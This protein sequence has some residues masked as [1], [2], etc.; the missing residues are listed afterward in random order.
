MLGKIRPNNQQ[1]LLKTRLADFINLGHPLVKLANEL[2][3]DKI[4]LAFQNL[5]SEQGRFSIPIIK[6]AGLLLLKNMFKESNEPVVKRWIENVDIL[7]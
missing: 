2:S 7:I 3:W 6:I 5:Y 1:N 4:E